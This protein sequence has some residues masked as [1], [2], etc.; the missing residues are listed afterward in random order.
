ML[1]SL[2]RVL[3]SPQQ[4]SVLTSGCPHGQLIERQCLTTSSLDS[5]T[6]SCR[7]SQC[8]NAELGHNWETQVISDGCDDDDG[9]AGVLL[10]ALRRCGSACDFGDGKRWAVGLGHEK[11]AEDCCIEFGVGTA[12]TEK[13]TVRFLI[14]RYAAIAGMDSS[15]LLLGVDVRA[16]KRYN[17]TRSFR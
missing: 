11:A 6:C 4:Q 3:R 2:P 13:T 7:K 14:A 1:D 9:L 15:S 17:L 5:G 12:C 10:W 8:G 16:K